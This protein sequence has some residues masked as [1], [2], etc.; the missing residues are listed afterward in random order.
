MIEASSC[1]ISMFWLNQS[2]QYF[3]MIKKKKKKHFNACGQI[4]GFTLLFLT[5][6]K[7]KI[8]LL[9]SLHCYEIVVCV[10]SSRFSLTELAGGSVLLS[11]IGDLCNV[12]LNP[13]DLEM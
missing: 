5:V 9:W 6:K 12:E 13:D 8:F 2:V 1:F 7:T 4:C 11:V 3:K 10:A